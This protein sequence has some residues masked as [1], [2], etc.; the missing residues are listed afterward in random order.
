MDENKMKDTQETEETE[1]E[2]DV[3]RVYPC[4]PLRGVSIF[5]RLSNKLLGRFLNHMFRLM[6]MISLLQ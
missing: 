3:R 5:P 2:S 4:V 1:A 6:I